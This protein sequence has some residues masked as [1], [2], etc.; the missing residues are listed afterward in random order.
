MINEASLAEPKILAVEFSLNLIIEDALSK[1]GVVR[2]SLD[3]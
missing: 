2:Y 1:L 3:R